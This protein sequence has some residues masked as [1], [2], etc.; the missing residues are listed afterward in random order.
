MAS[1]FR[2]ITRLSLL[3]SLIFLTAVGYCQVA[4]SPSTAPLT[5]SRCLI[6][7][8]SSF[9]SFSFSSLQPSRSFS[10][11]SYRYTSDKGWELSIPSF[12]VMTNGK[13]FLNDTACKRSVFG[14]SASGFFTS[15]GLRIRKITSGGYEIVADNGVI[16]SFSYQIQSPTGAVFWKLS[17]V[18]T[19]G[20]WETQYNYGNGG[21]LERVVVDYNPLIGKERYSIALSYDTSGMLKDVSINDQNQTRLRFF[22]LQN[23]GSKLT[24]ITQVGLQGGQLEVYR[25]EYFVSGIFRGKLKKVVSLLGGEI[26]MNYALVSLG[27]GYSKI[28]LRD[29]TT[30][31]K[32]AGGVA[33]YHYS[34][35]GGRV[36][37]REFYG[38]DDIK[39]TYPSGQ[40]IERAFYTDDYRYGLVKESF[41]KGSDGV[42]Y[43]HKYA[44]YDLGGQNGERYALR[45]LVVEQYADPANKTVRGI[46]V[47]WDFIS[48]RVLSVTDYGQDEYDFVSGAFLNSYPD[49]NL[50]LSI[51]YAPDNQNLNV[52]NQP[53][54]IT[55]SDN[56]GAKISESQYIYDG[57]MYID[58][59]KQWDSVSGT[60]YEARFST[61]SLGNITD[62]WDA[63][64]SHVTYSWSGDLLSQISL[65]PSGVNLTEVFSYFPGTNILQAVTFPSGVRR[66]ITLDE[67][68]RLESA[69]EEAGGIR[70]DLYSASY[71]IANKTVSFTSSGSRQWY[72]LDG[73]GVPVKATTDAVGANGF[74]AIARALNGEGLLAKVSFPGFFSSSHQGVAGEVAANHGLN[75]YYDAMARINSVSPDTA[76][77]GIGVSTINHSSNGRWGAPQVNPQGIEFKDPLMHRLE[78]GE[79]STKSFI[80]LGDGQERVEFERTESPFQT[81]VTDLLNNQSIVEYSSLGRITRYK[82]LR[83]VDTRYEYYINGLLKKVT[84][85]DGKTREFS[86]DAAGRLGSVVYTDP[87]TGGTEAV[88]VYWDQAM[89]PDLYVPKGSV[90]GLEGPYDQVHVGYDALG[91]LVELRHYDDVLNKRVF[92]FE[93]DSNGRLQ[94]IYYPE[95][96]AG[97]PVA[98]SYEY[99][100]NGL[101]KAITSINFLYYNSRGLIRE[102]VDRTPYDRPLKVEWYNNVTEEFLYAPNSGLLT[103]HILK[104]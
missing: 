82:D 99:D 89:E 102:I 61:D 6:N 15:S 77:D 39:I 91:R 98:V 4:V 5:N 51:S 37:G 73:F 13:I 45:H 10:G 16:H 41:A 53:S 72:Y 22:S 70:R 104:E 103:E 66:E 92:R 60:T 69:F 67:F 58:T 34:Y 50:T 9:F 52:Y 88:S 27:G 74:P 62:I 80:A 12:E 68:L 2:C 31:N 87:A 44:R 28:A 20:G 78:F 19:R 33:S 42:V 49:D 76:G 23:D 26:S 64:G 14:D 18:S 63:A 40:M 32:E 97:G 54:L 71:D 1:R 100:N 79:F 81:I 21:K 86:Y 59:I 35:S 90:A 94:T 46:E 75:A 7:S 11:L 3:L 85:G 24:S 65:D 30:D 17:K 57:Q 96:I 55:V 25:F 36:V 47:D 38:F 8:G 29:I 84:L 83:G 101:E 95:D 93:Y 56:T 48:N 43:A